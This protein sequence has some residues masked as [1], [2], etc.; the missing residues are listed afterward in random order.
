LIIVVV[1]IRIVSF[2][3]VIFVLFSVNVIE[4]DLVCLGSGSDTD[5]R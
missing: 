3:I 5:I 4:D 2:S 1:A